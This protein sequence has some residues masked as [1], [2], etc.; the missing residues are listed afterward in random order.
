M[1]HVPIISKL[2]KLSHDTPE[3]QASVGYTVRL[4]SKRNTQKP[5]PSHLSV[6]TFLSQEPLVPFSSQPCCLAANPRFPFLSRPQVTQTAPK[7]SASYVV[8]CGSFSCGLL[9]QTLPLGTCY[10]SPS[11]PQLP[12][13][14]SDEELFSTSPVTCPHGSPMCSS[15]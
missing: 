12:G 7:T 4:C 5:F 1:V 13:H 10:L 8:L 15:Q 2:G 3:F 14:L 9:P 6:D 11:T